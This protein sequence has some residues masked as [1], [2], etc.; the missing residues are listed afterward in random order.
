MENVKP[1]LRIVALLVVFVLVFFCL[2]W[3][4]KPN[5]PDVKNITGFY[6]EK[7]NTLDVVYIGG[8]AAFVYYSPL[9]AW[10]EFG[11]VSYVYGANT[12][13]PELYKPLIQEVLKTQQPKLII[14]DARCFQYRD[15]ESEN[16]QPPAEVPYRNTLN[17]MRLSR[18][19]AEFI[20]DYV[21]TQIDDEKLPYYLDILKYHQNIPDF[22]ET[23]VEM[24][25]G[26][27]QHPYCGFHFVQKQAPIPQYV[28]ATEEKS[29]V[30]ADTE[31]ILIDLLNYLD[32]TSVPCMFAVSPYAEK[33]SHKRVFNYV[34]DIVESRGYTFLDFNEYAEKMGLNYGWDFYNEDHVT[35]YGAEKYTRYLSP[36]LLEQYGIPS[37]KDDPDYAFMNERLPAWDK[38]KAETKAAILKIYEE[39]T[40]EE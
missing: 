40:N 12:I 14:L 13:Q 24:L 4:A 38:M 23:N 7:E 18:N 11:I 26:K 16:A 9:T 22:T 34:S 2:T 29:P 31:A 35:I 30:S 17:G 39:R 36:L 10:E 8:S 37:R 5:F 19:K 32:S 15:P 3:L 28:F 33:E 6:G 25:L 27:Y 20:H 21:G 1:L